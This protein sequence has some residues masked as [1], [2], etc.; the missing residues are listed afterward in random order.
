MGG[1]LACI[2]GSAYSASVADHAAWAAGRVGGPVTLLQVLGRR[3]AT[4]ARL[5]NDARG[6]LA[7]EMAAVEAER[8]RLMRLQ[9]QLDL[10]E[11]RTR[12]EAA[13]LGDVETLAR[14]GD[15]LEEIAAREA[16]VCVTVIG[17]RGAAADFARGH[18]GSNLE[19]IVRASAR[20][21]LI[22]A[23]AFRPVG[24]LVLAFDGRAS[25]LKAVEAVAASPL[26]AGLAADIVTVGPGSAE[27][28]AKL[29]GAVARLRAA[30]VAA[31]GLLEQ[32][33]PEAALPAL[34]ARRGADLLVMGAYGHSRLRS[35]MIGSTTSE[36][37]RACPI[38]I[39]LY[40]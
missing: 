4:P 16:G 8:A 35:L 15:L 33:Q 36:V 37:I 21:V 40:R 18:L 10:E 9:A 27:T 12:V 5:L 30:G 39:L 14:E 13:G 1:V 6:R 25:A 11:A 29:E 31:E 19:R 20:P 32:G 23:R 34:V 17:K 28:R 2:D 7:E 3:L 24:R 22:A 26:F 38:P